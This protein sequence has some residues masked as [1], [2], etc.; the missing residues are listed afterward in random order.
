M[1]SDV[2]SESGLIVGIGGALSLP[3]GWGLAQLLDV[4][5][6]RIPGLPAEAHF[7]VFEGQ[8]V[9]LHVVLLAGT[10]VA[11]PLV[12]RS[13]GPSAKTYPVGKPIAENAKIVLKAGDT[14]MLLDGSST[15]TISGPGTFSASAAAAASA[16]RRLA[17]RS[18]I[19]PMAVP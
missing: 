6:K 2:L 12:V 19:I 7:F 18:A 1:V 11:A 10:A 16:R 5:L 15:R 9:A 17:V 3:L 4:I 13:T 14:L 8:A